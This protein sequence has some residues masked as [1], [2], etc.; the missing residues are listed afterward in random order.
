MRRSALFG[1]ALALA[2]ATAGCSMFGGGGAVR[3]SPAGTLFGG[4]MKV[5]VFEASDT[6]APVSK[7]SPVTVANKSLVAG[8]APYWYHV[9]PDGSV[10]G[11]VQSGVVSWAK[12]NKVPLLPLINNA[13][14]TSAFLS[15]S[16]ARANA[17]TNVANL[18]LSNGFAGINI[19]FEPLPGSVRAGMTAF[20][21]A[22]YAKLHPKGKLV[23]VSII[24]ESSVS[25]ADSSA[26]NYRQ[27]TAN[28]DAA[29]L[30]TYDQHDDGSCPGPIAQLSWVKE[31]LGVAMQDGMP[32]NKIL[33][34]IADYGY[35]WTG[36]GVKG[37]PTVG[38]NAIPSLTG[39][40]NPTRDGEGDPHFTYTTGGT[41]HVV[42]YED[43]TSVVG[44]VKLAKADHLQG[45]ALWEEA[46]ATQPY[47]DAVKS[48]R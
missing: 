26:F 47:W 5:L 30:M 3:Q 34:G 28:S 21:T 6:S 8:L 35:D 42:W 45:L 37:T 18:V 19:D 23:E 9:Q 13:N 29:I 22:L 17:V 16:T 41:Q 10:T 44:K 4:G 14:T 7:V 38:L 33:L 25:A 27:I 20:I 12:S 31:R 1:L 43:Q 40:G 2:L 15:D 24:P 46:Y 48:N 36:C 11:S 32:A 39:S